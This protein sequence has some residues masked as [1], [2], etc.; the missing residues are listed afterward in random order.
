MTVRFQIFTVL[1][2]LC[3]LFTPLN[4]SGAG[5]KSPA[6]SL[7]KWVYE[8]AL[9][10]TTGQ[11]KK[12]VKGFLD[13]ALPEFVGIAAYVYG[14][15]VSA[16]TTMNIAPESI[17]VRE[18]LDR[19]VIGMELG[20]W[21]PSS[22]NYNQL[23]NHSALKISIFLK[24][25]LEEVSLSSELSGEEILKVYV[26][27]LFVLSKF[28]DHILFTEIKNPKAEPARIIETFYTL[29]V[30]L[31]KVTNPQAIYYKAEESELSSFVFGRTRHDFGFNTTHTETSRSIFLAAASGVLEVNSNRGLGESLSADADALLSVIKLLRSRDNIIREGSLDGPAVYYLNLLE[32]QA[33]QNATP[34]LQRVAEIRSMSV[35]SKSEFGFTV[36]DLASELMVTKLMNNGSVISGIP[37]EEL[38]KIPP[39]LRQALAL[40]YKTFDTADLEDHAGILSELVYLTHIL[41]LRYSAST[42]FRSALKGLKDPEGW[43]RR[44]GEWM[45]L[46]TYVESVPVNISNRHRKF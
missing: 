19:F 40:I 24:E 13:K 26:T 34:S 30:L 42:S 46:N 16:T 21:E 35:Y 28:I 6:R 3:L 39:R 11:H 44:A 22:L 5:I 41:D 29:T 20:A 10:N 14:N 2:L 45:N 1:V 8:V 43:L 17:A 12:A 18:F 36:V 33:I 4:L 9:S 23:V 37:R 31:E 7:S 32:M 38:T 27:Q 25:L 15:G